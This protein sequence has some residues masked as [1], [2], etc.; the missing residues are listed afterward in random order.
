MKLV[1]RGLR[2]PLTRTGSVQVTQPHPAKFSIPFY[3]R[4]T[5]PRPP[6]PDTNGCLLSRV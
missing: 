3:F 5:P 1:P 4:K 6:G 2:G